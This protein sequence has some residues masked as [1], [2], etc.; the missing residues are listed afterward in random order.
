MRGLD[1]LAHACAP[2]EPA[3]TPAQA[4]VL[5]DEE[6]KKIASVVLE[7]LQG[8]Q[9]KSEDQAPEPAEDPQPE[10]QEGETEDAGE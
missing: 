9:Q 10:P 3:E 2:Q 6:C 7:Q 1:M 8:G 4:H 5:T